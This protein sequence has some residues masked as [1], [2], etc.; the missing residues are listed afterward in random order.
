MDLQ[1]ASCTIGGVFHGWATGNAAN[2]G[3][4]L[5]SECGLKESGGQL[6][7]K[8]LVYNTHDDNARPLMSIDH[9]VTP[10]LKPILLELGNKYS[11][12][13]SM[14]IFYLEASDCSSGI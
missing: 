9:P 5:V 6:T 8:V 2:I 13:K 12:I 11:P 4:M 1:G 10:R 14:F 7:G 3:D